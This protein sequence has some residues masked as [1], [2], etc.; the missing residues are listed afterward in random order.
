[1]SEQLDLLAI[2]AHPDDV[3]LAVGGTLI[4]SGRQGLRVGVVDLTR[5]ELGTRG[6]PERRDQEASNASTFLGLSMRENLGLPDGD[7]TSDGLNALVRVLR[8]WCPRIVMTHPAD[9]R[10]PD[11]TAAHHLVR[12]ACFYSGLQKLDQ[13]ADAAPWR[14]HHLLHFAEVRHFEPD[15]V[16]DVTSVW[17]Q[18]T[19]ALRCYGSQ[20]H[21]PTYKEQNEEPET[22]ISNLQFFEWIEARAR[23]YGQ[24]AG[25]TYGEPFQYSGVLGTSNLGAFLHLEASFRQAK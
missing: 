4:L 14:P 25:C 15:F 20:I 6:T 22:Y 5:G 24:L 13:S 8:R 2:G 19:E 17:D 21:S 18:R 3:E 16:V 10:H 12:N 23:T 11:H 1:M 9:C 7:I